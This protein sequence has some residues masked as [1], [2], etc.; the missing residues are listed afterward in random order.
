MVSGM[1][2]HIEPH[3]RKRKITHFVFKGS[4][5]N[6]PVSEFDVAIIIIALSNWGN[7]ACESIDFQCICMQTNEF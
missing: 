5:G 2:I 6:F 3:Q 4:L 1:H 7:F